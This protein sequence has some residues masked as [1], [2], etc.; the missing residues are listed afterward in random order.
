M[1]S[2][3][4]FTVS[5]VSDKDRLSVVVS[6]ST[7]KSFLMGLWNSWL[8]TW[9]FD[10]HV[11][12]WGTMLFRGFTVSPTP[13]DCPHPRLLY[14]LGHVTVAQRLS[15][16]SC[17]R[18]KTTIWR[19]LVSTGTQW[20]LD[21][22]SQSTISPLMTQKSY[23]KIC[24]GHP[25]G[26]LGLRRWTKTVSS[27]RPSLH[28]IPH[29]SL[30]SFPDISLLST[31]AWRHE[32]AEFSVRDEN[33]PIKQSGFCECCHHSAPRTETICQW[34]IN[35]YIESVMNTA[36][37]MYKSMYYSIKNIYSIMGLV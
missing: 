21:K 31:I 6:S 12:K 25:G 33:N 34:N 4:K 27:W 19:D 37:T 13:P 9:V 26:L 22:I 18:P 10:Q 23:S 16:F 1:T 24:S 8:L 11:R 35:H 20:R 14:I 32:N 2:A 28:I 30:L 7:I 29:L 5:I 15:H 3:S 17:Q 36:D